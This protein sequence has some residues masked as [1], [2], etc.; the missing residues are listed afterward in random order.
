MIVKIALNGTKFT[1][2]NGKVWCSRMQKFIR[3]WGSLQVAIKPG[4]YNNLTLSDLGY[5]ACDSFVKDKSL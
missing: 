4:T 3:S 5:D 1:I 2:T